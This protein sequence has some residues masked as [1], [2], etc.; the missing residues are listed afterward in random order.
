MLTEE[1]VYYSLIPRPPPTPT[2]DEQL[3]PFL[4]CLAKKG[5]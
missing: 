2:I 1:Y 5:C 4:A 3:S